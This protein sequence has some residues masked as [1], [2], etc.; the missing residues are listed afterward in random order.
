MAQVT[1]TEEMTGLNQA[2]HQARQEAATDGK[3]QK[4]LNLSNKQK[5][6][7]A[8]GTV[9]LGGTAF[10][11]MGQN[12]DGSVATPAAA[13]PTTPA[14]S[15]AVEPKPELA[16]GTTQAVA[17]GTICPTEDVAIA[18]NVTNDMTFDQAFATAREEV[19]PG[20]MFSWNN[21]TYNTFY[22]EEWNGLSLEQKQDYLASVGYETTS[23]EEQIAE[24]NEVAPVVTPTGNVTV[25]N[26][27][28]EQDEVP[29]VQPTDEEKPAE[30]KP[31]VK[32]TMI[33]GKM[34][35]AI[36]NDG[37]GVVDALVFLD[38]DSN[39]P[40]ALID[41]AGDNALDTVAVLDPTTLEPIESAPMNQTFEI[42]MDDVTAINQE[43]PAIVHDDTTADDDGNDHDH[44]IADNHDYS[45]D[46]D[47]D[48][49]A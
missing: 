33:D 28:N 4:K 32:E 21:E 2:V 5:A 25:Q 45:H 44:D 26:V 18:H 34:A 16:H 17:G 19:G 37:D 47:V 6:A 7:I 11:A 27:D 20:G 30:T 1:N 36:D 31:E 41:T 35:Y 9:M 3:A 15:T 42:A 46:D 23:S 40:M 14:D 13:N 24:N 29:V 8:L 12:S 43:S 48:D 22:K 10:V 39:N 49:I 38:P